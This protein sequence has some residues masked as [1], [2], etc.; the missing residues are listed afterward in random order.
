MK[1]KYEITIS[2]NKVAYTLNIERN[3]TILT[4]ESGIGKSSL[5]RLVQSYEEYGKKS[6]VTVKCRRPCRTI[7]SNQDWQDRLNKIHSSIIFIDEGKDF[8]RTHEFAKAIEGND[9]YFVLVTRE[10][11]PQLSYSVD[12]ILSLRETVHRK[13]RV[14]SKT[15]KCY[16]YL[17]D[18]SI[19]INNTDQILTEDSHSGYEMYKAIADRYNKPCISAHGK[20]NISLMIDDDTQDKK[21][22]IADG[23]AFGSEIRK[24]AKYMEDYPDT[25]SLYLPECFEWLILKSGIIND[26]K[27]KKI[28]KDPMRYIESADFLSWERYFTDLLIETAKGTQLAYKKDSLNKAYLQDSN[29]DKVIKAIERKEE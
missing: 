1:G 23:A 4:G 24:V 11:L 3:I 29:V 27:V 18:F 15:Y 14:Y 17:K 26:E 2:N 28:L 5:V 25:V 16:S 6:A 8:L 20:S 10:G 22:V 21:I 19:I 7:T 9:N 12:A 13:K